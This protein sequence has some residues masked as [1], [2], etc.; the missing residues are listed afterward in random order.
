MYPVASCA[1]LWP[2]SRSAHE[3]YCTVTTSTP[4][5]S[6]TNSGMLAPL[7]VYLVQDAATGAAL[8]MAWG[9]RCRERLVRGQIIGTYLGLVGKAS[10]LNN[11]SEYQLS[12]SHFHDALCGI[13]ENGDLHKVC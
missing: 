11:E 1:P 6:K 2:G 4:L 8:P 5:C 9:L 12:L 3:Y 7:E 13:H 10:Q